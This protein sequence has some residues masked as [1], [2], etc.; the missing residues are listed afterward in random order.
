MSFLEVWYIIKQEEGILDVFNFR[1]V[2]GDFSEYTYQTKMDHH[3]FFEFVLY[4]YAVKKHGSKKNQD[5]L[6]ENYKSPRT[7]N[8]RLLNVDKNKVNKKGKPHK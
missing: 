5:L 7:D 2:D 3:I 1:K 8:N 6:W 4:K